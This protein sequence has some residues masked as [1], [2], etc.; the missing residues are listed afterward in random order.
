MKFIN[1]SCSDNSHCAGAGTKLK[2]TSG[3]NSYS[4]IPVGTDN[5]GFSAL[6]SGSV[7]Y[8]DGSFYGVGGHGY[9]WS[10]SEFNSDDAYRMNLYYNGEYVNYYYDGNK[11]GSLFSIR[12]LQ[13]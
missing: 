8:S 11:D 4:G 7:S 2:A 9:W 3:W 10:A 13:D 5:Y 12:C 6:P 1:P